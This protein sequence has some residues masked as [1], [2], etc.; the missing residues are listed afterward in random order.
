V[1]DIPVGKGIVRVVDLDLDA[2]VP[3]D[4]AARLFA[5]RLAAR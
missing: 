5:T 2:S 3:V 4:P 1:F